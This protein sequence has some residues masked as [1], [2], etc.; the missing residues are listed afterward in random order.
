MKNSQNNITF[1]GSAVIHKP[2]EGIHMN[3]YYYMLGD[4]G[5]KESDFREY[6]NIQEL[7]NE[8]YD[9]D[10][11]RALNDTMNVF[12]KDEYE[13]SIR[14]YKLQMQYEFNGEWF[15]IWETR[16]DDLET[17][18]DEM[19]QQPEEGGRIRFKGSDQFMVVNGGF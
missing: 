5:R 10:T 11:E 9:G 3:R 1:N 8:H 17:A 18:W 4:E 19:D 16:N 14:R 13:E 15:D 2:P 7:A 12:D 6:E